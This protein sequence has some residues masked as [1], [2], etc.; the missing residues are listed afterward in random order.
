VAHS[1]SHPLAGRTVRL[2]NA[3]DPVQGQVVA[4][5]EFVLEDWVDTMERGDG[6]SW[7]DMDGNWAAS[8]YA[9]RAGMTGLP[10]D[11]EVVYG[12]IGPF[13]H[14]VHETEIGEEITPNP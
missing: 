4:G 10:L 3:Q 8:H 2:V 7:M 6:R 1:S 11:D 5:T 14:M 9:M 12:K 13:G